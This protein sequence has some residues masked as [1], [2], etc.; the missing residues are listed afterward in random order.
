MTIP[1]RLSPLIAQLESGQSPTSEE[2][3][4]LATIQALD[5]AK[6]GEDFA[7]EAI[8]AERQAVADFRKLSEAP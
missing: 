1:D 2:L 8:A 3:R 7:R 6:L 4:R 5:L